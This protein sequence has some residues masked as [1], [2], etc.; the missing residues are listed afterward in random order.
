MLQYRAPLVQLEE[1]SGSTHDVPL[2]AESS[3]GE[4]L[5][6]VI[7]TV[8]GFI[9][10]QFPIIFSVV[11]LT[12]GLAAAYLYT[13]PPLYYAEAR[14]L[15]DTGKVQVSNQPIFGESPITM[16]IVDSQIELLRSDN[17]ALSIIKNLHLTQDPEFVGS[18][19]GPFGSAIN[20]L[21]KL[22]ASKAP[23]S[24]SESTLEQRALTVFEKR[25][26]V[27]RL[28]MTYIIGVG[29]QA[30]DPDRA[31][32]IA[33]AMA[34]TFIHDQMDA[35]YQTIGKATAWL[36]DRLNQ[37]RAQT[38]AAEHAVVEYK[39]KHNIVDT[40]GHLINEQQLSELNTAL[41][42]AR[43]DTAEAKARLDRVSQI[44]ISDELDPATAQVAT[45][46]DALHNEIISKLR[47][48]YLEQA[49]REAMLSNR[50][51]HDHL[52][53]VNIRNQMREI[54]RSIFDEFKRIAELYKSEYEIAKARENSV[55]ASLASTVAGSQTA[56][57]D[58]VELRQLESAAQSYGALYNNFQQRY[59]DYV[60]QQ[61]F[62]IS[63]GQITQALPPSASSSPKSFRILAMAT[64]GGL[65]LGFGLALLREIA[66]RVFRT[67]SQVAARLRT[68]CVAMLPMIKP[69][70]KDEAYVGKNNASA[71]QTT[72]RTIAR[73]VRPL[74]H[75][76]DSP[77]SQFSE[78][79]RAVKVTADLGGGSK[80]NKVIGI[81]S[82]LPDEGKSTVS[83]S[84]AQLCAHSGARVIL[85]DCDL[86]KRSLS[87]ELAPGATKGIID[88]L[89]DAASFND[90][91]WSDPSTKL[92]FLPAVVKSR[93][94]HTSEVLASAAM[95][96]L[97]D[98][99]RE[100]Y[101][102]VI[103]DLSPLAPVA[104][105]R[106]A[107]HLVNSYLFVIEWGKTRIE[108]V[109]RALNTA[110]GVYDNLLGVI[111]NKVDFDRLGRYDYGTY[112]ARYGYY[113]E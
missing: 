106:A 17:F 43:A 8:S 23:N 61:S 105:V 7:A 20:R 110:R 60:Q 52:A 98:L 9:R 70:P 10:R 84:L 89:T 101:D 69:S 68:E 24:Q 27:S 34:E 48:Q 3:I 78:S 103:V 94:T 11:P 81:T 92:S 35:K 107:T 56:N 6:T 62:P 21:L 72:A 57:R 108:V 14:I 39:T 80:S 45:V 87:H 32:E 91:I 93:L 54:R 46:A 29:F 66:D 113:S 102:Y 26:A 71:N 22:F 53:V 55:Q 58:Q 73:N 63:E 90:V 25:L 42:K 112:Y 83:A 51:G 74:R 16:A 2:A 64:V 47:Q 50:I 37:L 88:V 33:N 76:V 49:Q 96:R 85:V 97:F 36:Q 18:K 12:V 65:A 79:I 28:G 104:D 67:S 111:L 109:E 19:Q 13:T 77:L 15:I 31:A 1:E 59:T 4:Q 41:V 86:R 95:K 38:S 100:R 99:L 40:G 44:L 75:I 5:A 30:T 82:S